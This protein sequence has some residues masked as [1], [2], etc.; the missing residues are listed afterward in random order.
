MGARC[1][2]VNRIIVSTLFC[3]CGS[4][5]EMPREEAFWLWRAI[6]GRHVGHSFDHL[7]P[8]DQYLP[9]SCEQ[10]LTFW[11]TYQGNNS[12]RDSRTEHSND[13]C[14]GAYSALDING[15]EVN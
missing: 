6:L 10:V 15:N 9:R 1:R 2:V 12:I 8:D 3:R 7:D 5:A 14:S 4:F 13:G 11:S